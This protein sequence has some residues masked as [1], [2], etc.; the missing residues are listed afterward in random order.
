MAKYTSAYSSFVSRLIEVDDLGKTAAAREREDAVGNRYHISALCRGSIVLLSAHLEAYVRELGE[1]TLDAIVT[2][3]VDRSVVALRFFYHISKPIIEEI[4]DTTDQD[5]IAGKVFSFLST[6]YD[7]WLKNGPFS[8]SIP[9]EAFNKGFSNPAYP[10]ICKYFNRFGCDT[11][12]T[13]LARY[14]GADFQ[15]ATNMVNHL[16][17]M[18]NKIAHGDHTASKTPSELMDMIS[19][20]KRFCGATDSVFASWCTTHLCA[21]R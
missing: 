18:R 20:I 14:L 16:V 2:K 3:R 10:K 7:Y 4:K 12:H 13:E 6:E 15:P 17:E 5:K 11:Y 21:I 8:T 9:A 19:I 1:I